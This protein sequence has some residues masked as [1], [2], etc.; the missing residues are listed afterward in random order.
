MHHKP[1]GGQALPGHAE[2]AYSDLTDSLT[3]LN[4]WSPWKGQGQMER[5]KE[6]KERK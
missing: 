3:K 4:M 2:E 5:K 1:F 6:G